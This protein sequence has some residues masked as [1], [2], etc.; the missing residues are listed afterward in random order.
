VLAVVAGDCQLSLMQLQSA[1]AQGKQKTLREIQ[2]WNT[3]VE[4]SVRLVSARRRTQWQTRTR[5]LLSTLSLPL[6]SLL[7]DT[8]SDSIVCSLSNSFR[9]SIAQLAPPQ[10]RICELHN[11]FSPLTAFFLSSLCD[12]SSFL[13]IPL[14]G[15][16]S[17]SHSTGSLASA[18][19]TIHPGTVIYL[20]HPLYSHYIYPR[21]RI[22]FSPHLS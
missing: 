19:T 13:L 15:T 4:C 8:S 6:S 1:K 12:S 21:P 5:S 16:V 20:N 7:V 17:H 10:R 2:W 18:A 9:S 14:S 11:T 3:M 22:Y